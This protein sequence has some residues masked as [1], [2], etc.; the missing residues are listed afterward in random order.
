MALRLFNKVN[1]KEPELITDGINAKY[2][3]LRY[4]NAFK[5]YSV[6]IE[7]KAGLSKQDAKTVYEYEVKFGK[8][9]PRNLMIVKVE[10]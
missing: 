5:E 6:V 10:D 4:S 9:D 2:I 1:E 3:V 8:Q 7:S